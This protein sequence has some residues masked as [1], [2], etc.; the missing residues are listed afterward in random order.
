MLS[1]VSGKL[2]TLAPDHRKQV[3][4]GS[5]IMLDIGGNKLIFGCSDPFAK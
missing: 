1:I 2:L 4:S 5:I 3:A